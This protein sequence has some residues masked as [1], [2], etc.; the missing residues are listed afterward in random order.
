MW[1]LIRCAFWL[2][3]VF[4]SI[5]WGQDADPKLSSPAAVWSTAREFLGKSLEQARA[6]GEKA[7]ADAPVSCLQAATRISQIGAEKRPEVK[8]KAPATTAAAMH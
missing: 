3:I 8:A 4:V 7:C 2:T 1:F 5:D 6:Q